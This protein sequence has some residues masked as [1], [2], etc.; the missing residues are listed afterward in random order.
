MVTRLGLVKVLERHDAPSNRWHVLHVILAPPTG[1]G[2]RHHSGGA[3]RSHHDWRDGVKSGE[4]TKRST[5]P[6]LP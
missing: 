2:L 4:A 6:G 1:F 3:S 5:L